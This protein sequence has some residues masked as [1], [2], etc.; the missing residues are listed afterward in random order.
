MQE[1][2][3]TMTL[4]EMARHMKE[5]S[6]LIPNRVTIG[7]YARKLGYQVYK[8]MRDGRVTHLYVN[9]DIPYR[10]YEE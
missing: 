2:K 5:N 8:P 7:K 1:L 9:N 4:D 10:E 3:R 6:F